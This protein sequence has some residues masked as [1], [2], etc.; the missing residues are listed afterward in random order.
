MLLTDY[1]QAFVSTGPGPMDISMKEAGAS[2]KTRAML[3]MIDLGTTYKVRGQTGLG[4]SYS[5]SYKAGKGAMIGCATSPRRFIVVLHWVLMQTDSGRRQL[6][7]GEVAGQ[8]IVG[9]DRVVRCTECKR[10]FRC[11]TG[12][13]LEEVEAHLAKQCPTCRTIARDGEEA[14]EKTARA[15]EQREQKIASRDRRNKRKIGEQAISDEEN[16]AAE[17]GMD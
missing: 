11:E 7:P 3:R 4:S 5:R 15:K 17:R 13:D 6:G 16:E 9:K 1:R 12:D 10:A 8:F 2:A 14:A